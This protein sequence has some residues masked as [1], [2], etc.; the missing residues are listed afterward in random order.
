MD[1]STPHHSGRRGSG[2]RLVKGLV[3]A[4][5][6]LLLFE[7]G[8]RG[9]WTI[10]YQLPFF[11]GEMDWYARFFP[12]LNTSG[13][14][15][16]DLGPDDDNLDVLMLGGSVLD[17]LH[18]FQREALAQRL[19]EATGHQKIRLYD[20]AYPAHTMRDSVLKYRLL[21]DRHF[22]LVIVYHGIND[23]RMNNVEPALF[24]D[25]YTHAAWY[26]EI[27]RMEAHAD[28]LPYL[29]L[30]FTLEHALINVMALKWFTFYVP[31]HRPN[32]A[33]TAHGGDIKTAGP[34]G[35]NLAEIID[36]AERRGQPVLVMTFPWFQPEDYSLERFQ[37]KELVYQEHSHAT[38][39]WGEPEHIT[40]GLRVHN[41]RI[42]EVAAEAQRK[43]QDH[44]IYVDVDAGYPREGRYW[45]DICH[46]SREGE[47]LWMDRFIPAVAKAWRRAAAAPAR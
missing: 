29:T 41:E 22:D 16:A 32:L 36:T 20:L 17:N 43:G 30:P 46:F 26:Q 42:R 21:E 45:N 28:L 31:R 12:G 25:D 18:T 33:W 4:L 8:S 40:E 23:T 7:A 38:E 34:L 6:L 11:A 47:A 39:I 5:Y 44:V 9:Y 15:V 10:R 14:R 35:R 37:A 27:A 24:R 19:G 13:V 2:R 1:P 3:Y